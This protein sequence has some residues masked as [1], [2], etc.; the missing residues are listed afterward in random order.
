MYLLS[1]PYNTE[2]WDKVT[3]HIQLVHT[4]VNVGHNLDVV[5][6]W[7]GWKGLFCETQSRIVL[8]LCMNKVLKGIPACSLLHFIRS[9]HPFRHGLTLTIVAEHVV[10]FDYAGF[11]TNDR[12]CHNYD[13]SVYMDKAVHFA[14]LQ[15]SHSCCC[16]S[17][18]RGSSHIIIHI[19]SCQIKHCP[20]TAV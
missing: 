3:K 6:A 16:C 13:N 12:R 17:F 1:P 19:K 2:H 15:F 18:R 7:H 9:V 10:H 20:A 11:S 8:C 5:D 14:T 4:A